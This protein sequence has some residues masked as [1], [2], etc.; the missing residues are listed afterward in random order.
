MLKT[1]LQLNISRKDFN[2]VVGGSVESLNF[3]KNSPLSLATI[4]K[5]VKFNEKPKSGGKGGQ[6]TSAKETPA[7]T[8]L[9]QADT[10]KQVRQKTALRPVFRFLND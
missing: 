6:S 3:L 1:T 10:S 5:N 8:A 2:S 9:R 4:D 7:V